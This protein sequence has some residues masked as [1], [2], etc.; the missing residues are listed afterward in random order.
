MRPTVKLPILFVITFFIWTGIQTGILC[1]YWDMPNHDDALKYETLAQEC[2][3]EGVWYPG[4]HN[5]NDSFIFGP[6][7][8]NL[9]ICIHYLFGAFF[10]IR[11]L[12]LA[13]NMLIVIEIYILAKRLFGKETGYLSAIF[14]MLIFSNFYAPIAMLTDLPFTCLLL[15]A[16]LLCTEEKIFPIITGGIFIALANWMRPL[17]V[18][19]LIPI[20]IFLILKKRKWTYFAA[21]LLSLSITVFI[22]GT[23]SKSRTGNF[24]YQSVSGGFN[25]AMSCSDNANGLVNIDIINYDSVYAPIDSPE[26][27]FTERDNLYKKNAIQWIK[28]NPE[29]Y[30]AQLPYKLVMLYSED[31]WSERVKPNMGFSNV[32][33]KIKGDKSALVKLGITVA[34]KSLMYYF[35]LFF[36]CYYVWM[37][38]KKLFKEKNLLL[39]IPLLGTAVNL[40]FVITTRYHYPYMFIITIYAAE[41]FREKSLKV[42]DKIF[43]K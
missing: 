10:Y 37:N 25:L 43:D 11:F 16:I 18:I 27:T 7:Y 17:A 22:I 30:L 23:S 3:N 5:T 41:A 6:A 28:K 4:I 32:L 29:K 1:K 33:A 9:L 14:Y 20:I 39:L 42:I 34:I 24:I 2:V 15:T 8:I 26:Y 19:F 38:R 21:L 12:N 36:F 31:T 40:I 35:I 13:L